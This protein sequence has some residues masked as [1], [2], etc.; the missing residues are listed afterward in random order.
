MSRLGTHNYYTC[1]AA[2]K[3]DLI[4]AN[5]SYS[6]VHDV[7]EIY[8]KLCFSRKYLLSDDFSYP[9]SVK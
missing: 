2:G 5:G 8:W 6:D 3:K 4:R 9:K 1:V 7:K